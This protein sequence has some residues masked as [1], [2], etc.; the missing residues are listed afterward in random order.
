MIVVGFGL[1]G[2]LSA[3]AVASQ[4]TVPATQV[5]VATGLGTSGQAT[6]SVL[7]SVGFGSLP[8]ARLGGDALSP[9]VLASTL[10]D[11]F[12]AALLVPSKRVTISSVPHLAIG[13]RDGQRH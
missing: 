5:G 9:Q 1:G 8:M 10:H 3:F 6:G 13:E 12:F 11:T 2:A 4:N 7:G